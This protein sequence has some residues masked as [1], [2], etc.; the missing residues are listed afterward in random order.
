MQTF[1]YNLSTPSHT[2]L[3]VGM[4]LEQTS[5]KNWTKCILKLPWKG[6]FHI[7]GILYYCGIQDSILEESAV[8]IHTVQNSIVCTYP[9]IMSDHESLSNVSRV[10]EI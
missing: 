9:P 3:W 10:L 5:D 6:R 1:L 7:Y 8:Q 4:F 2:A